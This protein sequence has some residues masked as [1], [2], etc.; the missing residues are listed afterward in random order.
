MW[1]CMYTGIVMRRS[2]LPRK[3]VTVCDRSVSQG[4]FS[5][6]LPAPGSMD[7]WSKGV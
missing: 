2:Q 4:Q 3:V 1:A 6:A 7:L 5:Y